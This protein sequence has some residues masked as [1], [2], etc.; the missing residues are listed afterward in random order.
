M[1]TIVSERRSL[2]SVKFTKLGKTVEKT[3]KLPKIQTLRAHNTSNKGATS[4]NSTDLKSCDNDLSKSVL[5]SIAS[6]SIEELLLF[7]NGIFG[8]TRR[9][10]MLIT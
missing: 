1:C 7:E 5:Q 9:L 6:C 10:Y 3:P 8:E 2:R 4:K